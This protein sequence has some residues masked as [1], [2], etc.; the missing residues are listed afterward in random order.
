[1]FIM[2]CIVLLS[3]SQHPLKISLHCKTMPS[4]PGT[5]FIRWHILLCGE[6][7]TFLLQLLPQ[8]T[9]RACLDIIDRFEMMLLYRSVTDLSQN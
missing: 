8:I 7:P 4:N 3:I 2:N 5:Y 9:L 6:E 1:M